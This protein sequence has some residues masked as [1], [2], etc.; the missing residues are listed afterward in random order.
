MTI[1][2]RFFLKRFYTFVLLNNARTVFK[3]VF[4][5][6]HPQSV[7]FVHKKFEEAVKFYEIKLEMKNLCLILEEKSQKCIRY[8]NNLRSLNLSLC[9]KL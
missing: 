3:K 7:L 9:L 6:K 1:F 5:F 2:Q 8:L 4:S